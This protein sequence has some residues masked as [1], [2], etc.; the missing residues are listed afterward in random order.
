MRSRLMPHVR[1]L[2]AVSVA[3]CTASAVIH[4]Q[5]PRVVRGTILDASDR[6]IGSA[7]VLALS[8]TSAI[9][10]DSGRFRI[11]IS[12]RNRIVLDVRAGRLHA[13][14]GGRRRRG[15]HDRVRAAPPADP[16]TTD[17]RGDEYGDA[18]AKSDRFRGAHARSE[19]GRWGRHVHHRP[20]HREDECDARHSSVRERFVRSSCGASRAIG[21]PCT[22]R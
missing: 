9:S 18:P 10:D 8:G 2:F 16:A 19:K 13:V 14:A 4:A 12:H 15:R 21:S 6:P 17:G 20:R 7:A 3:C 22:R 5:V 1:H 11:E